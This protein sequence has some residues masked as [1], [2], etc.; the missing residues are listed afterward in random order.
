MADQKTDPLYHREGHTHIHT[1]T[2][3]SITPLSSLPTTA[4][5]LFKPPPN[6]TPYILTT[7]STIF[8]AQG[9]GQPSD[10]G[11]I[12][13]TSPT[14]DGNDPKFTVHQVR[15]V[16]P[17]ILH[18][19]TFEPEDPRFTDAD[20][21]LEVRQAVDVPTRVLH[22][23]LHTA[24]HVLGLAIHVLSRA[25]A[26]GL[27]ADLRD[28]KASHYPGA[29]F[30][31]NIGLIPGDAK[32]A[33]QAK[34]DELVAQDLAVAIHFWSGADAGA[35]CISGLDGA[36][37]GEGEEVRVVDI[38]GLGSYPCGGTHVRTLRELGRVVVRNIKRQKGIS[39]VS[40]E[41]VDG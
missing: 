17:A 24:G 12:T 29:A 2:L 41:V 23:K 1:T 28:G 7:P 36:A 26:A 34:V 9:G 11:T 38:G 35:K 40:Y 21:G 27:P 22:S 13:L 31:E 15:K 37:V 39:K 8:H 3:S 10:V 25:G 30:V 6:K 16:D 33:I 20:L 5:P 32:A 14:P 19:G 18:L 4:Q